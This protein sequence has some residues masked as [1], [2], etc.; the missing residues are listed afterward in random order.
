MAKRILPTI[1]ALR[2]R[3]LRTDSSEFKRL[4][5]QNPHA[6]RYLLL[7]ANL[8]LVRKFLKSLPGK[9]ERSMARRVLLSNAGSESGALF[10]LTRTLIDL[11]EV[12]HEK[13]QGTLPDLELW[14][15]KQRSSYWPRIVKMAKRMKTLPLTEFRKF[16]RAML[17]HSD[18]YVRLAAIHSIQE[19]LEAG[20]LNS[21][22][23]YNWLEPVSQ[24][25]TSTDVRTMA[26]KA[27]QALLA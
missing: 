17:H 6:R 23:A 12:M 4:G 20:Q 16:L 2:K 8:A 18:Y 15:A 7:R 11:G 10:T 3:R 21:G 25:D 19:L 26:R 9:R 27:M 24:K 5:V 1:T 13:S 22:T 14:A